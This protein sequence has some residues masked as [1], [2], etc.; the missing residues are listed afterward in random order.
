MVQD[1]KRKEMEESILHM[2]S[3]LQAVALVASRFQPR[4]VCSS[5]SPVGRRHFCTQCYINI[6][7]H[8]SHEPIGRR[9]RAER[10]QGE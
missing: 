6:L 5:T 1:L 2:P 3:G 7:A 8:E 10:R 9:K 4:D